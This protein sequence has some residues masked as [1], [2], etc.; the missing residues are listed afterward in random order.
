M[1]LSAT[2]FV[3]IVTSA[4]KNDY[5]V[6]WGVLLLMLYLR[7]M[8]KFHLV[9]LTFCALASRLAVLLHFRV[10]HLLGRYPPRSSFCARGIR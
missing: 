3:V 1:L 6:L 10:V 8:T 4:V 5:S 2:E 9:I 7:N